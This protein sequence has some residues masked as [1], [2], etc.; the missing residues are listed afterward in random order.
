MY[1]IDSD[2]N[3]GKPLCGDLKE[4]QGSRMN[5]YPGNK[6]HKVDVLSIR[7]C[8]GTNFKT[9]KVEHQGRYNNHLG[10]KDEE[11]SHPEGA[12]YLTPKPPEKEKAYDQPD[13][14]HVNERIGDQGPYIKMVYV[15][16]GK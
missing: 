9:A 5:K 10:I 7:K 8:D 1:R 12:F 2:E 15:L 14:W 6:D 13:G 11:G 4:Q 16:R 3:S